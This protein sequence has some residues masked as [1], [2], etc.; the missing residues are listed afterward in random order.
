MAYI[1]VKALPNYIPVSTQGANHYCDLEFIVYRC[2]AQSALMQSKAEGEIGDFAEIGSGERIKE[3]PRVVVTAKTAPQGS[4]GSGDALC[5]STDIPAAGYA[6]A[7][8]EGW[9]CSHTFDA[10][11]A[12]LSFTFRPPTGS[13]GSFEAELIKVKSFFTTAQAGVCALEVKAENFGLFIPEVK[14]CTF[15][16]P[17]G[18]KYGLEILLFEADGKSGKF[19]WNH[20]LPVTF[21]W[22]MVCDTDTPFVLLEDDVCNLQAQGFCGE[23]KQECREKGDHIYTLKMVLPQGDKTRSIRIRDTKWRKLENARGVAPDFS[24]QG[25]LLAYGQAVYLFADNQIYQSSLDSG[26]VLSEWR[27]WGNYDG[28]IINTPDMAQAVCGGKLYLIGGKKKNSDKMFASVCDLTASK[29]SFQDFETGQTYTDK[30]IRTAAA[31]DTDSRRTDWMIYAYEEDCNGYLLFCDY[32]AEKRWF[33]AR[34]FIEMEGLELFDIGIRNNELYVALAVESGIIIQK[35]E[36][37]NGEFKEEGKIEAHPRWM[38]W[39]RGNNSMFL[40]TDTG[41][42]QEGN[43]TNTEYLNPFPEKDSFPWCGTSKGKIV[44]LTA[45]GKGEDTAAVWATDTL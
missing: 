3:G 23:K 12:R 43:W 4:I 37:G 8:P 10:D 2:E 24:R 21:R 38:R 45:A 13:V 25:R 41:L 1:L 6:Y 42:Y 17:L 36:R 20:N 5:L 14:D 35:L 27:L 39:I 40:L 29:C 19:F 34:Y 22:D 11:T 32:D 44:C 15:T 26:Y 7:E 18:K 31:C 16:I 9:N 28:S 30:E 33:P